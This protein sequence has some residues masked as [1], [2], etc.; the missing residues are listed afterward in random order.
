MAGAFIFTD[1]KYFWDGLLTRPDLREMRIL[2]KDD[3]IPLKEKKVFEFFTGTYFGKPLY[4]DRPQGLYKRTL[5]YLF[6]YYEY[7]PD[8]AYYLPHYDYT[9]DYQTED[10]S[11][12]YHHHQ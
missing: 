1:T 7:N 10:W 3:Y 6:P 11:N 5:K 8:K 4:G 9:K 2:V 12:H